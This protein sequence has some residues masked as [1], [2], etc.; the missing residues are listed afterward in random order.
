MFAYEAHY[1]KKSICDVVQP[2]NGTVRRV[3]R[4]G[5]CTDLIS[6]SLCRVSRLGRC[7]DL[8]SLVVMPFVFWAE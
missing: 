7:T 6:L 1:D 2:A 5:R 8:I 3:S 4:L